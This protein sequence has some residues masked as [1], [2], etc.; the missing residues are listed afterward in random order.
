MILEMIF[1]VF[2][3]FARFIV[4]LFPAFPRFS[5]LNTSLSPLF[6]VVALINNFI[7]IPLLGRCLLI[8]LV[9][10]NLKFVWSIIMW[11]V[12]KIPGVS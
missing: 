3:F 6:T 12:R 8:V 5:S 9:I 4:G 10:Y 7:S 1:D 11:L 2:F